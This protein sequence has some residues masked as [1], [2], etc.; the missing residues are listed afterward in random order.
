MIIP[1]TFNFSFQS[2][3]EVLVW[4]P[5]WQAVAQ[6]KGAGLLRLNAI[7]IRQTGTV[8]GCM[9][10]SA[11]WGKVQMELIQVPCLCQGTVKDTAGTSNGV[12]IFLSLLF[13]KFLIVVDDQ[14]TVDQRA[15][16]SSVFCNQR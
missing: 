15:L 2:S 7:C 13:S 10:T 1:E 12:A 6:T 16:P 3:A 11:S 8:G 14:F 5:W 4:D 9:P